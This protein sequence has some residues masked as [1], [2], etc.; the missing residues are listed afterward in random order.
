MMMMMITAA[1]MITTTG[2]NVAFNDYIIR[3]MMK[4]VL[5]KGDDD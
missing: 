1:T 3:Q 4:R 2:Y 5:F